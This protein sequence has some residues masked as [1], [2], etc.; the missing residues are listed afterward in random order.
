MKSTS[1]ISVNCPIIISYLHCSMF[2]IEGIQDSLLS[3]ELVRRCPY[4]FTEEVDI[5]LHWFCVVRVVSCALG[6]LS[7]MRMPANY[8]M[9]NL[10]LCY[11]ISSFHNSVWQRSVKFYFFTTTILN[12]HEVFL[13]DIWQMQ[14][15]LVFTTFHCTHTK[16]KTFSPRCG[17]II[18]IMHQ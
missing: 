6:R 15:N 8:F 14:C 17:L 1:C 16:V 4:F 7:T 18:T 11:K 12:R 3:C 5:F 13:E 10:P 2:S 9:Q